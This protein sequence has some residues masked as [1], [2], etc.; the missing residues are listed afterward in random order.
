MRCPYPKTTP[1]PG[2]SILCLAYLIAGGEGESE[3]HA[4]N[5][6]IAATRRTELL[7][8]GKSPKSEVGSYS[9]SALPGRPSEGRGPRV[10]DCDPGSRTATQ[11]RTAEP[12]VDQRS[13]QAKAPIHRTVVRLS[14]R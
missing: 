7:F 14:L 4:V 5:V 13:E 2:G 10:E 3:K 9:M 6:S 1:V 8:T 12:R 11:R